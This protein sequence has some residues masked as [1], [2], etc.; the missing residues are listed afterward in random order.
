MFRKTLIAI[1]LSASVIVPASACTGISL[2]TVGNDLIQA[3]TI[4]WGE[5]NL[6]SKLIIS[7]RKHQFT[8]IM[9]DRKQGL[10]WDSRRS[11]GGISVS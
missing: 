4:E 3:R 1:V 5:S 10:C 7:P 11:F 6:N 9:P 8:S 2:S